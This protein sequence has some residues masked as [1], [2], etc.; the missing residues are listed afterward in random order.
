M[1]RAV[2]LALL[3][4]LALRLAQ[5]V[6]A[7]RGPLTWQMGA[8]EDFYYR[9]G[10]D[11]AF[12]HFGLT[13]GFAFMDPLYGYIIGAILKLGMRLFPL[14]LLQILVDCGTALGLYKVAC[15]FGRPRAGLIAIWIYAFTGTAIAYTMA[16]LKATWVAGY[17]IWWIYTALLALQYPRPRHLFLLGLLTGL[18]VALR[19]NFILLLP[20][21]GVLMNWLTWRQGERNMMRIS[22]GWL[23]L[24]IGA[25]IPLSLMTAR[26]LAI[27]GKASPMANNGG[28]V[29]HQLYNPENPESR[30]GV[31]TFVGRYSAPGEIWTGYKAEAEKRLGRTLLPQDVDHYWKAQARSYLLS[32]PW[33]DLSNG[34]RKLREASAPTEVPNTRNYTDECLVSP[35]LAALPLP[36]GWLFAFGI[37]GLLLLLKQDRRAAILIAPLAVGAITIAV[38]FAEDRFR[39]NVIGPFVVGAGIWIDALARW[40]REHRYQRTAI[41]LLTSVVLGFFSIVQGHAL[42][43]DHYPSDRLRLAWGYLKAGQ[44]ERADVLLAQLAHAHP[45]ASGIDELRGFLAMQDQRWNEAVTHYA[46]ACDQRPRQPDLWHNLSISLE[47]NGMAHE[48]LTAETRA[49]DLQPENP[50]YARRAAQL[51]FALDKQLGCTVAISP[52]QSAQAE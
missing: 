34:I 3:V 26:N 13:E 41:A 23:L 2:V 44:R 36:F 10:Q 8:D 21:G 32:H 28:I 47:K 45:N 24:L 9:F 40:M 4:T 48:S 37:P 19:G 16:I 31:P 5:M 33:Q 50:E 42:L 20:L 6:I 30:A 18:G 17:V 12:G 25:A 43:A 35:L 14:Y 39:F 29:L 52:P 51:C 38:F 1:R 22:A 46:R 7:I 15:L 49:L 27:S 11:V